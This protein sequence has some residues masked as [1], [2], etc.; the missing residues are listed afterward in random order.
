MNHFIELQVSVP[1]E[2]TEGGDIWLMLHSGSRNLGYQI[3]KAY[4]RAAQELN[5]NWFSRLP[6]KELA[7]LPIEETLG[8]S[9]IRDMNFALEYAAENRRRMLESFQCAVL[10]I[11]P[12]VEFGEEVNIH[13]N[14]AAR[15][16]H[17]GKDVWVHRKGA[18]SAKKDEMGI[19]PGSMGTF[20]YIVKGLGNRESFMSCSHGAGRIMGRMEYNR[21][22]T[23]EE[24]DK[25][26][27]GI[28]FHGW[29]TDRK[30]NVDLSESPGAYKDIDS[31]IAAELD[32]IEPQVKLRPLGVVKG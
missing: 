32:L 9:Y 16:K 6:S 10:E 18:T 22:H 21:T 13:H 1:M 11:F 25:Q 3:A 19:I 4:D 24:A 26:M 14:Y 23:V 30:G 7:F 15:E 29:G 28:F 17:F 2:V 12:D 31:V 20:S 27:E 5:A 8:Q